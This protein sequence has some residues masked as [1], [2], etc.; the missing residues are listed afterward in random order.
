MAPRRGGGGGAGVEVA[1]AGSSVRGG[2]APPPLRRMQPW[3]QDGSTQCDIVAGGVDSSGVFKGVYVSGVHLAAL[4]RTFQLSKV[5][6]PVEMPTP[7]Q[8]LG[9]SLQDGIP[10]VIVT[11][12]CFGRAMDYGIGPTR[13][14][15]QQA[16]WDAARKMRAD[17]PQVLITCIDL[18]IDAGPEVVNACLQSPLN[19]YRELMFHDGTWYTPAVYNAAKLGQFMANNERNPPK[20]GGLHFARKKFEWNAVQYQGMYMMGWKSVLEVRE[21]A[22]VPTRT[23]L[24]FTGDSKA[25]STSAIPK[26]S[27]SSAESTFQKMLARAR[28][29]G[30]ELTGDPKHMLEAAKVY[31]GRAA[32][33]EKTSIRE[34]LEVCKECSEFLEGAADK[35][36]AKLT[37]V[38]GRML[39]NEMDEALK[40]AQDLKA[41]APTPQLKLQAL[42]EELTCLWELGEVDQALESA[43]ASASLLAQGG[44]VASGVQ[45]LLVKAHLA[46]GDEDGAQAVRT[47]MA[48]GD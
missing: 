17:M 2:L 22:D 28:E 15:I 6:L 21:P 33:R 36:E 42:S 7:V 16:V 35:F 10:L 47:R 5:F 34:A 18:P 27:L 9:Q 8:A 29:M 24:D 32:P 3:H 23:D 43:N 39:L 45:N 31:L 25:K 20:G 19:E 4:L 14:E 44:E 48:N 46:K 38:R 12:G 40:V 37:S 13:N 41:A 26:P 1:G 11:R 30:D